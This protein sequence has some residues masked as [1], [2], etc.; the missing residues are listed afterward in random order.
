MPP[1]QVV[2]LLTNDAMYV[3]AGN[4]L[5][6]ALDLNKDG[7]LSKEEILAAPKT[8]R[9]LD[10]D[11]DEW[12]TLQELTPNFAFNGF[13]SFGRGGMG[14]GA[15]TGAQLNDAFLH[16][17]PTDTLLAK[18]LLERYDRAQVQR[19]TRKDLGLDKA[20]FAKLD[21]ND[22]GSL[23]RE[24][25]G[26]WHERP[27]DLEFTVRLGKKEGFELTTGRKGFLPAVKE[28]AGVFQLALEDTRV[29]FGAN[30]ADGTM[31]MFTRQGQV[32]VQSFRQADVKKQGFVE[33]KDLAG[34]Q[35]QLLRTIF[36]DLDRDHDGKL[37][38]KEVE[39]YADLQLGAMDCFVT[40]SLAD[41]GRAPYQLLDVNRDGRLS[42]RELLNAW[43]RLE[44]L[45]KD[46]KGFI[47]PADI[48]RQ[49]QVNVLKGAGYGYGSFRN[50]NFPVVGGNP[51]PIQPPRLPANTP[52]WFRKMDKN[53]DGDVSLAEFL[54]SREEFDRIDT[55]HDGLISAEE[56]I[57]FDAMMRAK[58]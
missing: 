17:R 45:D 58:K 57:R 39:T 18:V 51:T 6:K 38:E 23:D 42:Q 30:Q 2:P 11:D 31:L 50:V 3:E 27:A 7:K 19:L 25:L 52:E 53:G 20:V 5:F 21:K 24:E 1:V 32:F 16:I 15:P 33:L 48:A 29:N 28:T 46:K 49:F 4:A 47:A 26:H 54:G 43:S 56:A 22:D 44:S 34:P 36:A 13:Q 35:F 12:I 8:L 41:Q 40:L 10:L 14:M 37:T 55:D 9:K